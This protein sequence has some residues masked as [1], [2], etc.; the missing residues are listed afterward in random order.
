MIKELLSEISIVEIST[1]PAVRATKNHVMA[2]ADI[3]YETNC[4]MC[5]GFG[6]PHKDC[7]N[8]R[9][10]YRMTGKS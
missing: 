6:H 3:M 9:R 1:D 7:P 2:Q 10:L 8:R 5:S 4:L